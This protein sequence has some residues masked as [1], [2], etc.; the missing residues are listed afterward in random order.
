MTPLRTIFFGFEPGGI[1]MPHQSRRAFI[2]NTTAFAGLAGLTNSR[3]LA[4]AEELPA[5][6]PKPA[7]TPAIPA[8]N[9]TETPVPLAPPDRQP[10]DLEIPDAPVRKVGWAIV[11]LGQLALEEIMPA[12]AQCKLSTPVALV[13]GHLDKAKRLAA[14]YQV[15]PKAIYNYEN[16]DRIA[17]D[18]QIEIVYIVLPN[19]MHAEYTIRALRAGKHVLCEKPMAVNIVEGVQM[20]KAAKEANRKLMIGYR[21]HYEPMNRRVVELCASGEYG[22]IKTFTS[23]NCQNVKAP[24]IRLS[25]EL[26]GGPLGDIGIYSINA[27]RYVIGEEP[28]EVAAFGHQPDSDPRFREVLE[29]VGFIMRYPSGVIAQCDCSFGSTESRRYRVHCAEGFIEMDPAFSYRGLRLRVKHGES[30]SGA[31]Q[32][33]EL[34]VNPVNHFAA[35]MDHFSGCILNGTEP[36]TPA[37]MGIADLRIIAAL[38]ESMRTGQKVRI[39]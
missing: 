18:D 31:S 17:N 27:A 36:R 29:S 24:N 4:Q 2:A 39:V 37:E 30:S 11:G 19:S 26:G 12:F 1:C 21:L 3:L 20:Q 33:A 7:D 34:N 10:P 8:A 16:F 38:E 6:V 25:S 32:L 9:T 15:D 14:T 5:A 28:V 13:S 23:S 35:E 22:K